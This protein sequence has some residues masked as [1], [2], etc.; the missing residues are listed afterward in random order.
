[1]QL[2][3][4]TGAMIPGAQAA[5]KKGLSLQEAK[6][7]FGLVLM[8]E[9]MK[10][11]EADAPVL[12]SDP[13]GRAKRGVNRRAAKLLQCA[14]SYLREAVSGKR[15]THFKRGSHSLA[16]RLQK[17]AQQKEAQP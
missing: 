2:A 8:G 16:A 3:D 6:H 9:A 5:L 17:A 15:V 14:E 12:K 7:T 1:M 4:L 11:A 10:Q 13:L